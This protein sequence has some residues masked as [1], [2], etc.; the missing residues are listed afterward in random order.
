[1]SRIGK[2]PVPVPT[3]VEVRVSGRT[4]TAKGPRGTLAHEVTSPLTVRE[5]GGT[6][7]VERPDDARRSRE[8]HGLN[9][10]L[11]ANV[12]TGVSAGFNKQLQIRGVGYRA[13]KSKDGLDLSLG[14]SHPVHY[15][16]PEGITFE[17]GQGSEGSERFVTVTV[18]GIDKHRVGQVAAEIRALRK[19]EPYKGKGIRY[20]GEVVRKKAGKAAK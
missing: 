20:T 4:V 7:H 14:Y 13:Q 15:A 10:T 12:L 6:L 16:A 8:L 2:L 19:N 11:V 3:G 1:M 17:V 9:R 5:E 18:Q